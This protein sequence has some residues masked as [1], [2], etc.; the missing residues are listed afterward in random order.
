MLSML[1]KCTS[2]LRQP[3]NVPGGGFLSQVGSG[4]KIPALC[5]DWPS[6]REEP[7]RRRRRRSYHRVCALY[8]RRSCR[9]GDDLLDLSML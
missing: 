6:L 9:R 4:G 7:G 8:H 2:D 3:M 1:F 5:C